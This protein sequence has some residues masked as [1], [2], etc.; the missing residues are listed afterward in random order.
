MKVSVLKETYPG[1]RR[2]ALIPANVP[3]LMKAGLE[4]IIE[5]D[6]GAAA[7]FSDQQYRDKGAAISSREHA[8]QSPG[9]I[10]QV[11]CYGAN[12]NAGADD[13]SRFGRQHIVI[14]TCDPLG[15][16]SAIQQV[17][18]TGATLLALELIPRITRAQTMDILSSMATIA[19]YRAVLLAA[20]E[21]P[22]MFPLLMTA[23]GTL[24]AAKV[25]II[26]AGVAGLQAI[27][28]ARRLGAVVQAWDVRPDCREQVESL[29]GK[30]VDLQ[31]DT[32]DAQD[33]G[34]YAKDLG[35][36]FYR[37]QREAMAK[38]I[39]PCD[40]VITTASIPGK[41]SP[42]LI[43][44]EAVAGMH[45]GSVIVDLAAETGGNCE[46]TRAGETSQHNGVS[47]IGAVNLPSSVPQHAS[48]MFSKNVLTL[49]LHLIKDGNITLNLEDEIT[50]P[51][52]LAHAGSLRT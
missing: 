18:S 22:K 47:I 38:V 14:G 52:C 42:R 49:L 44:A 34:G 12:Q 30:F 28:V 40:V 25:F 8:L 2:V 39:A 36:E 9:I 27:S 6:A 50:G 32:A 46:L 5:S 20:V 48:L 19:G 45:P 10:L 51:M 26:G 3:Q 15:S 11:R 23:A 1:E 17:A 43:T 29:G 33:K 41:P 13:L 16:P 21:L 31:L 37:R 24:T 4:V 35:E 7:G